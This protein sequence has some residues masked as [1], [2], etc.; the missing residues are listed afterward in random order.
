MIRAQTT[1]FSKKL[2]NFHRISL[3]PFYVSWWKLK[4]FT[5]MNALWARRITSYLKSII[6]ILVCPNH[7]WTKCSYS[8]TNK[9]SLD[10]IKSI[11]VLLN[12][13]NYFFNFYKKIYGLYDFINSKEKNILNEVSKT[14]SK[15]NGNNINY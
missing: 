5:P 11:Y 4:P 14:I 6:H 15:C 8:F 1:F 10:E 9:F 7:T 12:V 13:K 3:N 2:K